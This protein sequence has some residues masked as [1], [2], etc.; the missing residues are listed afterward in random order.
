MPD[1]KKIMPVN[2]SEVKTIT[3]TMRDGSVFN[4]DEESIQKIK[5]NPFFM[6]AS[7]AIGNLFLLNVESFPI[8]DK[9]HIQLNLSGGDVK[10]I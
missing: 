7:K 9:K 10:L 5:I 6:M 4:L 8:D 3:I 2:L 1:E